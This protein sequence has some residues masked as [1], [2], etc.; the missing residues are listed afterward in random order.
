QDTDR[1]ADPAALHGIVRPR[2]SHR[3]ATFSCCRARSVGPAR[4][5][6]SLDLSLDARLLQQPA[7]GRAR[8]LA[9]AEPGRRAGTEA[10]KLLMAR[11]TNM[12]SR[13]IEERPWRTLGLFPSP[14]G[15]RLRAP[16]RRLLWGG[17]RGGGGAMWR[18]CLISLPPSPTLP[19]K[20]GGSTP[21]VCR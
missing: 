8:A 12:H 3:S 2:L 20:G 4:A 19:H 9:R 21:S 15:P 11:R 13:E 7:A 18:R 17:V 10:V 5:G 14:P 6:A 1:S 16:G